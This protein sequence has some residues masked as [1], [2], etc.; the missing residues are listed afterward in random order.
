VWT[1]VETEAG[2]RLGSVI[3]DQVWEP[4]RTA[5]AICRRHDDLFAAPVEPHPTPS[6]VCGCGFHAVRDP[7]DAWSY[8]RGRDEAN[9]V[10]RILG[11]VA[12][13]GRVVETERGW[14]AASAYPV[15]LYVEHERVARALAAY[16][17]DVISAPC[18]SPSSPTCTA[19]PSRFARRS[20]TSSATTS[21]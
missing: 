4:A 15:R 7:V 19:M 13:W 18:A 6:D 10:G 9:V 17:V 14:R 3:H 21:T 5:P 8:L 20:P 11:E 16:D 12:L 2:L 1:L